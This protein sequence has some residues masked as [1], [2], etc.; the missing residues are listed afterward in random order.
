MKCP[1]T[2]SS[3][4]SVVTTILANVLVTPPP[5]MIKGCFLW[6]RGKLDLGWSVLERSLGGRGIGFSSTLL[7]FWLFSISIEWCLS[8]MRDWGRDKIAWGDGG[9]R[10]LGRVLAPL[11]CI[12]KW[13]P[14]SLDASSECN[15]GPRVACLFPRILGL[16]TGSP[17]RNMRNGF[18]SPVLSNVGVSTKLLYTSLASSDRVAW[19]C[20]G[21][22]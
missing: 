2:W 4:D 7:W 15:N 12:S 13:K 9:A 18:V 1:S 11:W 5:G 19:T 8:R 20:C 16:T 6:C 3:T 10:T 14:C 21:K 17:D 22:G